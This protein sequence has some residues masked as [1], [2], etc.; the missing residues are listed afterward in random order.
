VLRLSN[1]ATDILFSEN[2]LGRSTIPEHRVLRN[3]LARGKQKRLMVRDASHVVTLRAEGVRIDDVG[4][5]QGMEAF[6]DFSESCEQSYRDKVVATEAAKYSRHA[7]AGG[8]SAAR[9]E[10]ETA[11]YWSNDNGQNTT[12]EPKAVPHIGNGSD[13]KNLL[14]D[15][16]GR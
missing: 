4:R 16:G 6:W 7:E 10:G 11:T 15:G 3:P 5:L 2:L 9:A 8:V 12:H 13:D 14:V 1:P